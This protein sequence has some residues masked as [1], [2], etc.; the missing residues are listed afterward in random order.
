[1]AR[2]GDELMRAAQ[3]LP[4]ALGQLLLDEADAVS[5]D[6]ERAA[7]LSLLANGSLATL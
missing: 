4:R 2:D 1:L 3:R 5:S 7:A 6:G